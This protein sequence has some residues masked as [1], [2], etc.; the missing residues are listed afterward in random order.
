M[1][2]GGDHSS[3]RTV[4]GRESFALERFAWTAPDRLCVAGTFVDLHDVPSADPA[5]VVR[6]EGGWRHLPAV[7]DGATGAP[8]PGERWEATFAWEDAPI[9]FEAAQLTFGDELYVRLP[10]PTAGSDVSG[11]APVL[12]VVRASSA[13]ALASPPPSL[14]AQVE[15]LRLETQ[16][17]AAQERIRE[18]ETAAE[19]AAAELERIRGDLAVEREQR[20]GESERFQRGL[21]QVGELAE[22]TVAEARAEANEAR[23]ATEAVRQELDEARA[24]AERQAAELADARA[25]I[26]EHAVARQQLEAEAAQLRHRAAMVDEV[27]AV[28]GE[29]RVVL[30]RLDAVERTLDA[31]PGA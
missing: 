18:L 26:E 13:Q 17:L 19:R 11:A 21:T 31:Q 7:A 1:V 28:A 30:E 10:E 27:R 9:P 8:R 22:R 24:E 25:A 3:S 16:L 15:Q 20:A 12:E 23:A 29:A 2:A 14:D 4:Q 5:L 6:G